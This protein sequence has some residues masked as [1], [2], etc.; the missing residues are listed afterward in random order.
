MPRAYDKA[1]KEWKYSIIQEGSEEIFNTQYN[2]QIK[3]AQ[4]NYSYLTG[5]SVLHTTIIWNLK[6]SIWFEG[7]SEGLL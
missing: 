2:T 7:V 6:Q 1:S 5:G 3:H 4:Q